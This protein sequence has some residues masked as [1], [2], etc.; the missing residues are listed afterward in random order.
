MDPAPPVEKLD[1]PGISAELSSIR[2]S[3][4]NSTYALLLTS[5]GEALSGST[6]IGSSTKSLSTRSHC[7][8]FS[9]AA[10]DAVLK[11]SAS[12]EITPF[13][14]IDTGEATTV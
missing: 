10:V 11:A 13:S 2:K 1:T 8:A 9:A 4:N 12:I 3:G 5:T 7:G 6:S 14:L